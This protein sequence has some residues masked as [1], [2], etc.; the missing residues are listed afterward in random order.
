MKNN[1][2]KMST[3]MKSQT[4]LFE[5]DSLNVTAIHFQYYLAFRI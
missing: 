3:K 5:L 1:F 4:Y 2:R